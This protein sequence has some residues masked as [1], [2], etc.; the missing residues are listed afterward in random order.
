MCI[1]DRGSPR[2]SSN[3]PTGKGA[4]QYEAGGGGNLVD[5]ALGYAKKHWPSGV[6]GLAFGPMGIFVSLAMRAF[7]SRYEQMTPEEKEKFVADQKA[8]FERLQ[9]QD[10]EQDM[11]SGG[12]PGNA[13]QKAM[14]GFRQTI[15]YA[16]T[17]P[18]TAE[19]PH[20]PWQAPGDTD[21]LQQYRNLSLIHI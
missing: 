15:E 10:R 8:Q 14:S 13:V 4:S 11:R 3:R 6:A 16:D 2:H 5:R 9:K 20:Q 19:T 17:P 18:P 7:G 21:W 1:R 12:N